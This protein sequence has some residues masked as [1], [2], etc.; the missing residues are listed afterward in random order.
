[1]VLQILNNTLKVNNEANTELSGTLLVERRSDFK[2]QVKID[3]QGPTSTL[4]NYDSYPLQVEGSQ[5]GIAIK[6]TPNTPNRNNN[7]MSFWD[8][9]NTIRGRIEANEGLVGISTGL[10]WDLI[11]IPDFGDVIDADPSD[12]P[13][14]VAPKS[15]FQ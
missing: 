8:G 5:Q 9:D 3:A 1:M 7:Y 15:V 12:T 2:G 4:D 14:D 13:P 10:I 6:I 11:V